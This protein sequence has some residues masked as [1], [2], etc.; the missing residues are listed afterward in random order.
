[1]QR[2]LVLL[3][4]L[5][6]LSAPIF[7]QSAS[8]APS[9]PTTA[10]AP[11]T[12]ATAGAT[13]TA[14]GSGGKLKFGGIFDFGGLY[15]NTK[16]QANTIQTFN[17]VDE[18][19][20]QFDLNATYTAKNWGLVMQARE[21]GDSFSTTSSSPSNWVLHWTYAWADLVGGAVRVTAGNIG[22]NS[23][24][25]G[26]LGN[27]W[28]GY[29]KID[30]QI[31]AMVEFKP[32]SGLDFGAFLPY[33]ASTSI[34]QGQ[35]AFGN[36]IFGA[37]YVA[38][39]YD[40]E[41]G[42]TP[43]STPYLTQFWAGA[44]YTGNSNLTLF[45]EYVG[46]YLTDSVNGFNY[47]DVNLAYKMGN[48][49]VGVYAQSQIFNSSVYGTANMVIPEIDYTV[50]D[51]DLGVSANLMS[52]TAAGLA[53]ASQ[54]GWEI[55]PFLKYTVAKNFVITAFAGVTSGAN[56]LG[57]SDNCIGGSSP[58]FTD[59]NPAQTSAWAENNARTGTNAAWNLMPDTTFKTGASFALTF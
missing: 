17:A 16:G 53:T 7:A 4:T 36:T 32:V 49:N 31:G 22:S 58:G 19:R 34:T 13:T 57:N 52:D 35:Q 11:A 54:T 15:S 37:S 8:A 6:L 48:W 41:A 9:A 39:T 43:G 59:F 21:G 44:A 30:G 51:F 2:F 14:G 45:A 55:D 24:A 28:G 1:M 29:G 5:A 12:D 26:S 47:A 56:S 38:D 3:S 23:W 25:T 42:V 40:V 27:S 18:D 46:A 33:D 20:G 50:N 10:P